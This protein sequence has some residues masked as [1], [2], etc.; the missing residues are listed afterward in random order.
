MSPFQIL[1]LPDH[2]GFDE[3]RKK[4]LELAKK[5]KKNKKEDLFESNKTYISKKN[6]FV[7]D[8]KVNIPIKNFL[9]G[10]T[11]ELIL[12][13]D[14]ENKPVSINVNNSLRNLTT[15]V[16]WDK[17]KKN[18]Q[19]KINPKSTSI[20]KIVDEYHLLLKCFMD[21]EDYNKEGL[22]TVPYPTGINIAVHLTVKPCT[23]PLQLF[24]GLGLPMEN[25][26]KGNMIIQFINKEKRFDAL[27][28][29]YTDTGI[30]IGMPI[31]IDSILR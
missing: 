11:I 14:K 8:I 12:G 21:N 25:N 16:I 28:T 1:G 4:Y 17:S 31:S 10:P 20:Y 27:R 22:I 13:S 23:E 5:F 6:N 18:I 19:V 30:P 7:K 3:I 9:L 29:K 15:E 26:E 24:K 2:A